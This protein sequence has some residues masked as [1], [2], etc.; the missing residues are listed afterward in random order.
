M[1]RLMNRRTTALKHKSP[2][3]VFT[4]RALKGLPPKDDE[5]TRA[6][7]TKKVEEFLAKRGVE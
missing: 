5:A 7:K 3:F 4:C 6:D 1:P 2:T